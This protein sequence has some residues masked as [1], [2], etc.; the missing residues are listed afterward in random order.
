MLPGGCLDRACQLGVGRQR[1]VDVPVGAQNI[2][3]H[4]RIATIGL[5]ASLPVTLT[6]PSCGTWIN[7]KQ[8]EPSR[9]QRSHEQSLVGLD[10]DLDR[11]RLT[12]AVLGQQLQ[13][14]TKPCRV[15]ADTGPGDDPA[16]V[17]DD[18]HVMLSF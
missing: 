18:G 17:I 4:H 6:V 8:R 10:R 3:Q 5:A 14:L 7:R 9:S 13:Q 15:I 16:L 2:G 1:P 11:D 12:I